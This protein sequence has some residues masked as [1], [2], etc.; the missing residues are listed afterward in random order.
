MSGQCL[1]MAEHPTTC[2][3]TPCLNHN[4]L[5]FKKI[6]YQYWAQILALLPFEED[7]RKVYY[8]KVAG[9]EYKWPASFP[10][11]Q[12]VHADYQMYVIHTDEIDIDAAG[13][14]HCILTIKCT[15]YTLHS[16]LY[17]DLWITFRWR[18]TIVRAK[19]ISWHER[20]EINVFFCVSN[21]QRW[22]TSSLSF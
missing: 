19:G 12:M 16:I 10:L 11:P 2:L 9:C 15:L 20:I 14:Y 22:L 8:V 1:D 18:P 21:Y 7:K 13:T 6:W 17:S 5:A 3:G 4:F